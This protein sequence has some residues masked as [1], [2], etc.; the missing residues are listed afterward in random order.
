MFAVGRG[1]C[2]LPKF[3]FIDQELLGL[4][5]HVFKISPGE[6][7]ERTV[8]ERF[9]TYHDALL[10]LAVLALGIDSWFLLVLFVP[11]SSCI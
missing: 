3:W 8:V 1:S 4:G 10:L 11:S 9:N 2:P 5:I 7:R 6:C